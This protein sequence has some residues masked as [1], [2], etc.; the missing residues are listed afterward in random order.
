MSISG[1]TKLL[2]LLGW[3][4]SHSLSPAMHN[5]AAA[6]LQLDVVYLPLPV[7]PER[8]EEALHGLV[9]LGFL[10]ANVTVPHKQAV[11]PYISSIEP[12]AEAIGAVNTIKVTRTNDRGRQTADRNSLQSPVS[13]LQS[14]IS[15]LQ[16]PIPNL[17]GFNTDW[18]GF[19]A[20]LRA[21][22]IGIS[23]RDCVILGAGG[24]ARAVAYALAREGG[25]VTVFARRPAQAAE[26]VEDLG[27]YLPSAALEAAAWQ[28]LSQIQDFK[29]ALIVNTTPVGMHPNEDASPLPKECPLPRNADVYDVIYNPAET[30]LMRQA[31]A[32]GCRAF[33]GLGMLLQQGALAFEIWLG[34]RPSLQVMASALRR[35]GFA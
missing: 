12:A 9:A 34:V 30:Q 29:A 4:V 18:S 13:N 2:G 33:N 11:M 6:A 1:Q 25:G 8:V 15:N 24:S 32:A 5:A 31:R 22:D 17:H 16:S 23:G 26:L 14:P 27:S 21:N 10:G 20:D 19:L 35:E 3:P 28:D 7:M